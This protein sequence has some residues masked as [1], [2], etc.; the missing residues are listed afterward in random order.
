MSVGDTGSNAQEPKLENAS[1]I[2]SDV[3][4]EHWEEESFGK[5][6]VGPDAPKDP[7]VPSSTLNYQPRMKS[8]LAPTG[9]TR[10]N[11]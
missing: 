9:K 6:T 1:K 8:W 11:N 3:S 10:L 5:K 2:E 4:N 7:N